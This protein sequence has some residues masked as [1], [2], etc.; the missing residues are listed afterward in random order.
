MWNLIFKNYTNELIYRNRHRYWKNLW[1][2]KEKCWGVG[3]KSGAWDEHTHNTVFKK[4][5][6][7]GQ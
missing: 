5:N 1:W 6:E 4:D 7:Q 2:L 3:D